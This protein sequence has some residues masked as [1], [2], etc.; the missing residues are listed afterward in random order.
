MHG[1]R[2]PSIE[3][4]FRPWTITNAVLV[5]RVGLLLWERQGVSVIATWACLHAVGV[6][7]EASGGL[8]IFRT[9]DLY[10]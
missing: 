3:L 10:A 8:P 4:R 5:W 6:K 1:T 7:R 2:W 9:V